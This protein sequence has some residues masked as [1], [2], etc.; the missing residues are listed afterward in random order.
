MLFSVDFFHGTNKCFSFLS[1]GHGFFHNR[2]TVATLPQ[3]ILQIFRSEHFPFYRPGI[4]SNFGTEAYQ[5]DFLPDFLNVNKPFGFG[6]YTSYLAR[7][8]GHGKHI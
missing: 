7:V 8:F 2:A 1:I 4:G 3:Y 6:R 5:I